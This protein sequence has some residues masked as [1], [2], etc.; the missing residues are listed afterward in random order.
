MLTFTITYHH[1]WRWFSTFQISQI[2]H[3]VTWDGYAST[4]WTSIFIPSVMILDLSNF[5]KFDLC[6]MGSERCQGAAIF[7][8]SNLYP[9]W[10]I[11]HMQIFRI[12]DLCHVGR[13]KRCGI[14]SFNFVPLPK[15]IYLL[16]NLK[17]L[18]HL[19]LGMVDDIMC[20]SY[21][22]YMYAHASVKMKIVYISNH[23]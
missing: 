18:W 3:F 10:M 13:G 23:S 21:Y 6:H 1:C 4:S 7:Q 22:K 9:F 16:W 15:M 14:Q 19:S 2:L 12:S 17:Q 5:R 20:S 8:T 11:L